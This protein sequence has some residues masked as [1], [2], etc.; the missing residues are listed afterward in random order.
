MTERQGDLYHT[1]RGTLAAC[2]SLNAGKNL[3][4]NEEKNKNCQIRLYLTLKK[5]H[6][7][8]QVGCYK[9]CDVDQEKTCCNHNSGETRKNIMSTPN[10]IFHNHI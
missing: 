4:P 3:D 5:S 7:V 6:T 9:R 8:F 2:T 10:P 1:R